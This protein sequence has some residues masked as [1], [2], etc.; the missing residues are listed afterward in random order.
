MA[1]HASSRMRSLCLGV[2]SEAAGESALSALRSGV[3]LL[4]GGQAEVA[5]DSLGRAIAVAPGFTAP[6]RYVAW[7]YLALDQRALARNVWPDPGARGRWQNGSWGGQGLLGCQT[8]IRGVYTATKL[9]RL[10]A[11]YQRVPGDAKSEVGPPP[12]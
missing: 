5:L 6:L 12:G 10:K 8:S 4:A 11:G 1:D 2:Q 9:P 3:N 7:C